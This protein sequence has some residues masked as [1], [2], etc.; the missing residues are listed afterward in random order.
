MNNWTA[1]SK[2]PKPFE[3]NFKRKLL[4]VARQS[5]RLAVPVPR[6]PAA[7][8]ERVAFIPPTRSLPTVDV[9]LTFALLTM[10]LTDAAI[11]STMWA[12]R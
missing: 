2:N 10:K 6:R 1:A 7:K 9:S 12:S 8:P 4:S 11:D 5:K 3:S